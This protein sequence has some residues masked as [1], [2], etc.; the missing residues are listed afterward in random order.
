MA[1]KGDG[2]GKGWQNRGLFCLGDIRTSY[3]RNV[4]HFTLYLTRK[5]D[6]RKVGLTGKTKLWP[7]EGTYVLDEAKWPH[8]LPG[9][10]Y[11]LI[12]IGQ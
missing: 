5:R 4:T 7:S 12:H 1:M 8:L 3:L 6:S 2:R 9:R 10:L 11:S